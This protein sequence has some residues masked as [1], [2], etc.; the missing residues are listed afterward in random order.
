MTLL[1]HLQ[2]FCK[3]CCYQDTGL[4]VSTQ[5]FW[6]TYQIWSKGCPYAIKKQKDFLSI[7]K[8]YL[9]ISDDNKTVFGFSPKEEDQWS[10]PDENSSD[11]IYFISNG[12]YVKIGFSKNPLKRL[13]Q[14]QTGSSE[15]LEILGTINGTLATEKYLHRYFADKHIQGEWF[16]LNHEDIL[17]CFKLQGH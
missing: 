7:L 16:A 12:K 15:P 17:F 5:T 6:N 4:K 3:S 9:T 10:Y 13:A 8:I 14:L 11:K 2:D 1:E